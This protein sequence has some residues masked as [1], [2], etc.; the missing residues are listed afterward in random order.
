MAE[1]IKNQTQLAKDLRQMVHVHGA[2]SINL[3]INADTALLIAH[4]LEF[5]ATHTGQDGRAS[6]E[7]V[8]SILELKDMPT[9]MGRA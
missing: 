2:D 5:T 3:E 9:T 1:L 6:A 4:A 7:M 8:G